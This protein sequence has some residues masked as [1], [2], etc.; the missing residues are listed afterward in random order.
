MSKRKRHGWSQEDM[1]EAI[2]KIQSG[3][4][5]A[6]RA[7]NDNITVDTTQMHVPSVVEA[8]ANIIATENDK[9]ITRQG[10]LTQSSSGAGATP[11]ST[12]S[13][14]PPGMSG[15]SPLG[16][17]AGPTPTST[18]SISP[19]IRSGLTPPLVT[20]TNSTERTPGSLRDFFVKFFRARHQHVA[21]PE[22]E[23]T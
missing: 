12:T 4:M 15:P 22:N 9:I 14:H 21:P 1:K 19:N 20:P 3:E 18:G 17:R 11:P 10:R 16:M 6:Y 23:G 5:T 13:G 8:L 7:H 2:E